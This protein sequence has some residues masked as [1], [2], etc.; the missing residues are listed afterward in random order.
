VAPERVASALPL[1]FQ[2]T[3]VNERVFR[4]RFL[5]TDPK[6]AFLLQHLL[7]VGRIVDF[8]DLPTDWAPPPP[9]PMDRT[10]TTPPNTPPFPVIRG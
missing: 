8:R 1:A 6:A 4:I 5:R 10:G 7:P 3:V 9:P 2:L